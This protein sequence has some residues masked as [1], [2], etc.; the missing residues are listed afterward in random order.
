MAGLQTI[1]DANR[2]IDDSTANVQSAVNDYLNKPGASSAPNTISGGTSTFNTTKGLK[3]DSGSALAL[4][5]QYANEGFAYQNDSTPSYDVQQDPFIK[6][7]EMD[8]SGR[9]IGS[10]PKIGSNAQL[11]TAGSDGTNKTD[12]GMGMTVAG[13][14]SQE[15][16]NT[17]QALE[18]TAINDYQNDLTYWQSQG[19]FWFDPNSELKPDLDKYLDNMPSAVDA[20]R[21]SG[22][23]ALQKGKT[24]TF[25]EGA[26]NILLN[27]A[28]GNHSNKAVSYVLNPLSALDKKAGSGF[29]G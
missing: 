12:S 22:M 5:D 10:V 13:Q 2:A 11:K 6:S 9:L 8:K 23:N 21:G 26:Y 18:N 17:L 19:K 1:S 7:L 3:L 25:G 24:D 14:V 16:G 20:L 29:A 28:A 15:M 27:P 4:T